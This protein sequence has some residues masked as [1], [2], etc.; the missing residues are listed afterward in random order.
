MLEINANGIARIAHGDADITAAF[1]GA[2]R[3]WPDASVDFSSGYWSSQSLPRLPLGVDEADPPFQSP[4]VYAQLSKDGSRLFRSSSSA[5]FKDEDYQTYSHPGGFYF[6]EKTNAEWSTVH[7]LRRS[8]NSFPYDILPL[9]QMVEYIYTPTQ[10]EGFSS[11]NTYNLDNVISIDA[12]DDWSRLLV[13]Y[14]ARLGSWRMYAAFRW[15]SDQNSYVQIG[16]GFRTSSGGSGTRVSSSISRMAMHGLLKQTVDDDLAGFDYPIHVF[17]IDDNSL[18][19]SATIAASDI[20]LDRITAF[21]M[22]GDGNTIAAYELASNDSDGRVSTASFDG[23]SWSWVASQ[24]L[25]SP[26]PRTSSNRFEFGRRM[27][28]SHDGR[29]LVVGVPTAKLSRAHSG[30]IIVYE[31]VN[32]RW[33]M[34]GD[35]FEANYRG[36]GTSVG[37]SG[38]GNV[39][40]AVNK[41]AAWLGGFFQEPPQL[42]SYYFD[43]QQWQ[44]A[45]PPVTS[46]AGLKTFSGGPDIATTMDG[47]NVIVEWPW[48]LG[49]GADTTGQVYTWN[50]TEV[51]P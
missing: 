31:L 15:S 38:D 11:G 41:D 36:A 17:D 21:R 4:I 9:E 5:F 22:S 40:L 8:A 45:G 12:S 37:I 39:V 23:Q 10:P 44:E 46:P 18:R 34:M 42:S 43:G 20:G 51:A 16:G 33:E 28:L 2:N 47:R 49:D 25:V 19:L 3:I 1:V 14:S 7:E 24:R 26:V 27:E 35:P 32:G 6:F 50:P 29:R 13:E 30:A 48:R